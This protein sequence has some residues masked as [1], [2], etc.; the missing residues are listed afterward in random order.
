MGMAWRPEPLVRTREGNV[1][2]AV[3][4]TQNLRESGWFCIPIHL[5]LGSAAKYSIKKYDIPISLPYY[6]VQRLGEVGLGQ[7]LITISTIP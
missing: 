3:V 2:C 5:I 7:S 6:R 4:T 1:G